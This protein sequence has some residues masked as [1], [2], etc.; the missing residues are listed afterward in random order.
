[1][2]W[3]LAREVLRL[4]GTISRDIPWDVMPDLFFY[5]EP[6]EVCSWLSTVSHYY[7]GNWACCLQVEKDEQL[8]IEAEGQTG[9]QWTSVGATGEPLADS[10]VAGGEVSSGW[11]FG[12][13]VKLLSFLQCVAVG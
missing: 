10:T 5:R 1:M 3:F 2:W 8:K 13:S 9:D 4:R 6:E 7:M 11:S 12:I